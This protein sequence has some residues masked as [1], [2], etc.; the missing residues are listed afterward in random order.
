MGCKQTFFA[1][2]LGSALLNFAPAIAENTVVVELFTSQGCS[3]CPPADRILRQLDEVP[4]IVPL[5]LNVDYWDYLGWKDELADPAFSARQRAYAKEMRS[6]RVYTPQMM[7]DGKMDVVGSRRSQV[8]AA[9]DAYLGEKD[10]V[11]LT[12]TDGA[13]GFL[14]V[15]GT[16]SRP[17]EQNAVVW[18]IGY[19][20]TYT[21]NVTGG[22]NAGEELTYHNVVRE[23]RKAGDWRSGADKMAITLPKPNGK[24]GSVVMVQLGEVGPILGAARI[25]Y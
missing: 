12:I 21:S 20:A 1:A 13:N 15:T 11:N 2:T 16:A 3:S 17:L 10:A 14:G 4:G 19:D 9:I 6:R 23:W 7:I 25:E 22:E 18:L 5:T 8:I 24:S